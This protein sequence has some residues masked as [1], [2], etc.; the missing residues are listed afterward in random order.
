MKRVHY[1]YEGETEEKLLQLLKDKKD[2]T[3]GRLRKHNLWTTEFKRI[4]R[5]VNK[6]DQLFFFIDTDAMRNLSIFTKN[7][8][9]LKPYNIRLMV[10]HKNLE[11]E[12]CFSCGKNSPSALFKGFY[13]TTSATEFKT[14][15]NNDNSLQQKLAANNFDYKKL[16]SRETVFNAFLTSKGISSQT[17]YSIKK[18]LKK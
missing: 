3:P 11:D 17:L 18:P 13:D 10:Q 16:W 14:R 8:T 7:I 5:T 9:Q 4:E 2:I 12:L 15:F 1:F 6:V